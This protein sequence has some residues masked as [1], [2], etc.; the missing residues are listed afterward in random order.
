MII[1]VMRGGGIGADIF[2]FPSSSLDR[3]GGKAMPIRNPVVAADFSSL[4]GTVNL[5]ALQSQLQLVLS[6]Y[7]LHVLCY[8]NV[9]LWFNK[10]PKRFVLLNLVQ[11]Q[12]QSLQKGS[13]P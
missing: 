2:V 3:L 6:F 10:Q 5:Y 13:W 7:I 12:G 8:I 9:L 4:T 1:S 11:F